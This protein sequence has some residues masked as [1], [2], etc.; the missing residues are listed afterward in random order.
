MV[1]ILYEYK[2]CLSVNSPFIVAK[3]TILAISKCSIL[4]LQLLAA[5]MHNA[6]NAS[7]SARP[8]RH[9][10]RP[11]RRQNLLRFFLSAAKV[12]WGSFSLYSMTWR[13][14][15]KNRFLFE[16]GVN[17]FALREKRGARMR[18]LLCLLPLKLR[19]VG[20]ARGLHF[21]LKNERLATRK[22]HRD[23]C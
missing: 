12:Y 10:K 21:S 13:P 17:G 14:A 8:P 20:R 5:V 23:N 9:P 7:V 1:K 18:N 16:R 15:I 6:P 22:S 4:A 2:R 3:I 11:P 19:R